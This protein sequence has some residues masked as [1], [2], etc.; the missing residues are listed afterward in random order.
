MSQQQ[1]NNLDLLFKG[2]V[3]I[4]LGMCSFFLVRTV[5]K[6]DTTY[7]S[8]IRLEVKVSAIEKKLGL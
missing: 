7:D 3:T 8:V 1:R 5:N 2:I 4:L 6:V